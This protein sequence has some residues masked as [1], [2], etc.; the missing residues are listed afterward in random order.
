MIKLLFNNED[1]F[2]ISWII[3]NC[4]VSLPRQKRSFIAD[5]NQQDLSKERKQALIDKLLITRNELVKTIERI[6]ELL[7]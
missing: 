3:N 7:R 6:E 2:I 1:C 4:L 5:L